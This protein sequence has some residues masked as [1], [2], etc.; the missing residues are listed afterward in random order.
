MFTERSSK[1]LYR[2]SISGLKHDTLWS[3]LHCKTEISVWW[4]SPK[5]LIH[6]FPCKPKH[7]RCHR[8]PS[9]F[10][11]FPSVA[12]VKNSV[13]PVR[14]AVDFEWPCNELITLSKLLRVFEGVSFPTKPIAMALRETISVVKLS[15]ISMNPSGLCEQMFPCW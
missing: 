15:S 8:F 11:L 2:P 9:L 7:I 6:N 13:F 3:V 14:D 1:A 12:S 4:L 10:F 5:R